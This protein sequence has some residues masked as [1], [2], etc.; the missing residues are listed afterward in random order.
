VSSHSARLRA[1]G[2]SGSPSATSKSRALVEYALAQLKTRGA[3][4]ALLDLASLPADGLLGRRQD[5]EVTRALE[6]V[7]SAQVVV[8]GTPVYRATY[9]GLLKV[10]F[11]LLPQDAL[12]GKI[13]LPLVAGH[14][15]AHSLAVDHGMRPL[16]ASLG[17]TVVAS[18]VY[19]TSDQFQD[20]T[21]RPALLQAVDRAVREALALARGTGD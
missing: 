5:P 8:A 16:F 21:P 18:A 12:V 2:I 11:D 9:T 3:E 19:A 14:G 6:G 10:F 1:V 17:A 13:A 7:G 15:A 20:G 4:T